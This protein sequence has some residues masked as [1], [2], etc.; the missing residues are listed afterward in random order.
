LVFALSSAVAG[1]F[2]VNSTTRGKV[3]AGLAVAA[4]MSQNWENMMQYLRYMAFWGGKVA[5]I[6]SLSTYKHG[7]ADASP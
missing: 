3:L 4:E 5:G 2:L 6:K 1:F 7:S